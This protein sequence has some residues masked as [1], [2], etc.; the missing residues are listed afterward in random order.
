MKQLARSAFL[1]LCAVLAGFG[2]HAA[3]LPVITSTSVNLAQ[4][5]LTIAGQNFGSNP[6]VTLDKLQFPVVSASSSLIVTNFPSGAPASSFT[7]GTYFLTLVFTNQLPSAF[8]VELGAV[9][10]QG[11]AGTQGAP[12]PVG[13]P[14]AGGP[15][16]P[17]GP[18]GA[19]GPIGPMGSAGATGATGAAGPAGPVGA[20][21][22]PGPAGATGATGA[23]GATGPQGPAGPAAPTYMP[24]VFGL[25]VSLAG[26]GSGTVTSADS[27]INCGAACTEVYP[28]G[29]AVTL[30]ATPATGSVFE[31]W[32]SSCSGTA[33]C[34]LTMSATQAVTAEFDVGGGGAVPCGGAGYTTHADG[35]GQSFQDCNPLGTYTP[36][37][38]TE[39]AT[40]WLNSMGGGTT[41]SGYTCQPGVSAAD[42][43]LVAISTSP[44]EYAVWTYA[45]PDQGLVS[46]NQQSPVCPQGGAATGHWN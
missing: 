19:A 4:G 1:G 26:S 34:T 9:G 36:T 39:A 3:G 5:T 16:G 11:P 10:P 2:V 42:Q 12:G 40:A 7:P 29:T 22:P 45:G 6:T 43:I 24:S 41:S 23:P 14:G 21:G 31:G 46:L 27:K 17:Q 37:S 38:A 28:I 30:T 15:I 44:I 32:S 18:T 25:V 13:P 33:S 35:L 8:T 20:A